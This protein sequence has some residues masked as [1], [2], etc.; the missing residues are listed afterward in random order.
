MNSQVE[1]PTKTQ[2]HK[3]EPYLRQIPGLTPHRSLKPASRPL[4]FVPLRL[5]GK[6][7]LVKALLFLVALIGS[8]HVA[9]QEVG[10]TIRVNTRVVFMD[11]LV[12][13]KRT[14]IPIASLKPENF[15]VLDD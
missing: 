6:R 7:L 5:C 10:D 9:A 2:R 14:G 12:K 13:E 4:G 3:E 11:A 1:C 15:E 8:T